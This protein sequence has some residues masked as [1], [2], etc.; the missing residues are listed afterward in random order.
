MEERNRLAFLAAVDQAGG[1]ANM[2]EIGEAMGLE[3]GDTEQLCTELLSDGL[4]ELASLSG[5][6]RI[7]EQ[8]SSLAGAASGGGDE[9]LG[10]WLNEAGQVCHLALDGLAAQ[11]LAVD[12]ETI[13]SQQKRTKPHATVI[14]TCL[15]AAE[16]AFN[17]SAH[18]QAA[19]LARR[20]AMLRGRMGG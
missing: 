10:T 7:T 13:R 14:S 15:G 4:L 12:L 20:A 17:S 16:Q 5:G 2:W 3:R 18:P 11:D 6:V 1:R 19:E 9:D 8:G